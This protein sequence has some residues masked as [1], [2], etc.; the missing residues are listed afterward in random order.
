M[1]ER[2]RHPE[3]RDELAGT[4]WP[5]S[6]LASRANDAGDSLPD[7]LFAD[8]SLYPAGGRE[9][10]YLSSV[11]VGEGGVV[12]LTFG[13]AG[14][15]SR[16]SGSFRLDAPPALLRLLDAAG[17]PAGV[18][19]PGPAGFGAFAGWAFGA[20]TFTPAQAALAAGACLPSPEAGVAAVLLDDGTL[21]SGD[22][23]LVG[24]GGVV[25]TAG[26]ADD[27]L[28]GPVTAVR[29]DAVG[30]PL[31]RRRL[32]GDAGAFGAPRY[33][34]KV[35]VVGG[36]QSFDVAPD[37]YG[38]VTLAAAHAQAVDSVLRV[39]TTPGGLAIEAAG[40]GLGG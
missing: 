3:Y 18:V 24:E 17:R 7:G 33:V 21:L 40:A 9:G 23:W 2:V 10:A 6:P 22:V 15:P 29:V 16:A 5:F 32:C 8:L 25:L 1:P 37:A 31:Y 14:T 4:G 35:R 20:H 36:P 34:R 27:P 11:S 39:R 28:A 38:N 19:A 13:D 30:D 12:T 26:H